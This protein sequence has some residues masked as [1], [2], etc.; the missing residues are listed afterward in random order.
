MHQSHNTKN[1]ANEFHLD[2][3]NPKF[4]PAEHSIKLLNSMAPI[5]TDEKEQMKKTP[6]RELVG[7]L[8]YLTLYKDQISLLP[9]QKYH[10]FC[11]ITGN[12]IGKQQNV[13]LY[14]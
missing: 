3:S 1:T 6:Y 13:R 2:K 11:V 14:T 7:K 8:N 4:S 5:T 12:N 9:N 10:S